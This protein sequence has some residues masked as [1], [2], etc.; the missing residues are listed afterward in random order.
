MNETKRCP[1]CGEEIMAAAKKCKYCGEWLIKDAPKETAQPAAPVGNAPARSDNHGN[2]IMVTVLSAC[3]VLPFVAVLFVAHAT[4]PSKEKHSSAIMEDVRSC[5]RDKAEDSGN[6]VIPG[7]G[8]LA[9]LFL[10]NSLTDD[11][12]DKAFDS[13]NVIEYDKSFFWSCAKIINASNPS[14]TTVSFGIFGFVIPSVAWEDIR[15]MSDEQKQSIINSAT[16]T[17][18]G[19]GE[20]SAATDNSSDENTYY[21]D[22]ASSD[23]SQASTYP[24]TEPKKTSEKKSAPQTDQA[25]KQENTAPETA[26]DDPNKGTGFHL[27]PVN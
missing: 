12:I 18:S 19:A 8:S 1:Y 2:A 16:D 6:A 9:S 25:P 26:P 7:L 3:I 13:N 20:K 5:V 27:E 4:V 11:V 22:N 14:G 10:S 21:D 24:S 17:N 23:A 15:L